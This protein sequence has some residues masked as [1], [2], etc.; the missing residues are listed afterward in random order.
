ME[1]YLQYWGE[2]EGFGQEF[3]IYRDISYIEFGWNCL[4]FEF[5][6]KT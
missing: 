4:C 6:R 5:F 2:C 3:E 1:N